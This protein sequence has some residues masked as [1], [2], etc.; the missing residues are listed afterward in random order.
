MNFH[1][2]FLYIFIRSNIWRVKDKELTFDPFQLQYGKNSPQVYGGFSG[3]DKGR[4]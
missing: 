3:D 2:L 4:T 1:F